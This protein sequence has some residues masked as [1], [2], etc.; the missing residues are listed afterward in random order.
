MHEKSSI[1]ETM[2]KRKKAFEPR[3]KANSSF[4]RSGSFWT[5][6]NQIGN[7]L[8]SIQGRSWI[9][10][11]WICNWIRNQLISNQIGH[12]LAGIWISYRLIGIELA[13]D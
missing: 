13:I 9:G 12:Q 3:F 8:S 1:P 11:Q 6:P 4:L 10:N 7:W 5:V 2:S